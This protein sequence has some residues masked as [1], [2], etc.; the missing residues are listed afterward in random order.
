MHDFDRPLFKKLANNDT[1]AA[2]GHQ[3]G[4]VITTDMAVYFPQLT[5]PT[6]SL[7]PTVDIG[8]RAALFLENVQVGLVDT[9]YQYQTWGGTRLERRL[10]SNLGAIRRAA[11]KH[12]YLIIERSLSDPNFYRL[13][14]LR[15]GT[16]EFKAFAAKVGSRNWGP[17]DLSDTPVAETQIISFEKMQESRELSPFNMF[18]SSAVL[19]DSRVAR[20]AR[21]AAFKRRLLPLYDY[22]CAICGLS[23]A[24]KSG[25][26]EAEAAHIVP[27]SLKGAD[28]ARNGLVLCKS[29]HWAFD[30]GLFGIASNR[31]VV[32]Q[33]AAAAEPRNAHLLPFQGKPITGPSITSFEPSPDA[34][35]WHRENVA[36]L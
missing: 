27:R 22:R 12:D 10:T 4:I 28:D 13:T 35:A 26:W 24:G 23:H 9:R 19:R 29:H 6:S 8:V 5:V 36:G 18:D 25:H 1:G 17:V 20:I 31:T 30:S 16:Q 14:L 3:G 34:L 7:S 21:S 33:P 11:S 2:A 15:K 32:L